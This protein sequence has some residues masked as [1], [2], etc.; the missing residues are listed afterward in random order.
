MPRLQTRPRA[1]GYPRDV[2]D[3]EWALVA[4]YLTLNREDSAH[5]QH[6]PRMVLRTH[7][8]RRAQPT[9]MILDSRTLQWTPTSGAR[10]GYDGAKRRKGA[11][12]HAAVDTL[13]HLLALSV[14]P[15]NAQDRAQVADLAAQVQQFTGQNVTL[16]Y[17]DQ[18]VHGQDPSAGRGGARPSVGGHHAHRSQARLRPA[19]AT[20]GRRAQFRV[21]GS[22]P[23][24]RPR[25]RT[26]RA[27][28]RGVA[29]PRVCLSHAA[30]RHRGSL[31]R[32]FITGSRSLRG[33]T[34]SGR[35]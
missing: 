35:F 11:K 26:A 8:G 33:R 31:G 29:L 21:G 28:A 12:V 22:L 19:A 7:A 10:A 5:R 16:G 3:E 32:N 20:L 15:A 17:V 25:L 18:G 4:P 13:G 14:T 27:H 30:A 9:A 6:D 24:P 23:S 34:D 2:S 1:T